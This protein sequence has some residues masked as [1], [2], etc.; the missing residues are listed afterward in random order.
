MLLLNSR[1]G[2]A[3]AAGNGITGLLRLPR[4]P[5]PLPKPTYPTPT[6]RREVEVAERWWE[7]GSAP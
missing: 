5:T 7:N 6:T 1:T 3:I 2:H 4:P